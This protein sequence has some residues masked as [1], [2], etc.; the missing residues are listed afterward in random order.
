MASNKTMAGRGQR[1]AHVS[2]QSGVRSVARRAAT[3]E[4]DQ[5][6]RPGG[7]PSQA[8]ELDLTGSSRS[9]ADVI[10]IR[11]LRLLELRIPFVSHPSFA[12]AA[13][14]AE[15]IRPAPGPDLGRAPGEQERPEPF[16]RSVAGVGK[17]TLLTHPQHVYLFR[18]MNFLKSVAV[19][20]RATIDPDKPVAADLDRIEDLLRE[21]GL[22]LN[23]IIHANQGLVVSIVKKT[24][25]PRQDFFEMVSDGNLALLRASLLFDFSRGLRFSTYAS[26][27]IV[28]DFIRNGH[29]ERIRH[30][31]FVTGQ[32]E[33]FRDVA[34]GRGSEL[35]EL[36]RQESTVQAITR[37][38]D[39][40]NDRERTI[41]VR[42]FGLIDDEQTLIE[43]AR[44]LGISK[45]RVRQI[46][47]RALEKLCQTARVRK[48]DVSD[49]GT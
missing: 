7:L 40:L 8:G 35:A 23:R 12:D 13:S 44:E 26:W 4:I 33:L 3:K 42:R 10:R 16:P 1:P 27:V 2:Y 31:R 43:I 5:R 20:L 49:C 38:L 36:A 9:A 21:A 24:I 48:I 46:E 37:L 17:A 22:V 11:A 45:E 34:D 18:K 19:R 15:I 32:E 47:S 39:R 30:S 14:A 6:S 29:K 41:I 25:G 28:N